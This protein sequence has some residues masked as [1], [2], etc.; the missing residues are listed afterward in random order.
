MTDL[1]RLVD[2]HRALTFVIRALSCDDAPQ[3]YRDYYT[4]A[5]D[6][7][8]QALADNAPLKLELDHIVIEV[9]KSEK[10]E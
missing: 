9:S 10:P 5:A 7:L 2:L 4:A 1:H 3:R 8:T 6:R